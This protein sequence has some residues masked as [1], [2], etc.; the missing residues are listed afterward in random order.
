MN[1][2]PAPE[3]PGPI[4]RTAV[5]TPLWSIGCAAL[6]LAPADRDADGYLFGR[7][8]RPAKALQRTLTPYVPREG[9]LVFYDDHNPTWTALFA[10]AG[11][12]PPL[13]MGIVVKRTDGRMAILEAG[14]DDT[15]SVRLLDLAP[16]L[17]Q[18]HRDFR[19]TITIRRCKVTL[20]PQQSAAQTRF[21]VAQ[22]GK[23][24]A[25]RRLLVQGTPL[26]ARG[27]LGPLLARTRLDRDSWICSELAVATGT[28]AGL[29]D[30]REVPANATYQRD[31]VDNRRHDLRDVWQ[32]TAEW[33]PGRIK[34]SR[35][36]HHRRCPSRER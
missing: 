1:P 26:R 8:P 36:L 18:F 32:A 35:Q 34:P 24:Y 23:R 12:G 17:R 19:G 11:T 22:D 28:V 16:R 27:P 14:P 2:V 15:L 29:F 7:P 3:R 20:S 33:L 25:A 6:L 30:P 31:L 9:D 5:L 13:H 4:E 10:L 21:A